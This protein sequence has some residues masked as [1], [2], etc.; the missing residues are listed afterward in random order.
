MATLADLD[1]ARVL[2]DSTVLFAAAFSEHGSARALLLAGLRGERH[3]Y[4]STLV[5]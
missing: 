4:V 5:L 1:P 2:L 3:I